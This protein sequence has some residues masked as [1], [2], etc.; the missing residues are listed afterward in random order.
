MT[1]S[2]KGLF[3]PSPTGNSTSEE[4]TPGPT[5]KPK[6]MSNYRTFRCVVSVCRLDEPSYRVC[7]CPDLS[8]TQTTV[9]LHVPVLHHCRGRWWEGQQGTSPSTRH[10]GWTAS[11]KTGEPGYCDPHLELTIVVSDVHEL[12]TKEDNY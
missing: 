10:D 3:F 5:G 11:D 9:E 7:V 8:D 12:N 6:N 2:T 4:E 1:H